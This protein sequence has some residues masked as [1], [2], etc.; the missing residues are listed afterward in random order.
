MTNV[1]ILHVLC[2]LVPWLC[3]ISDHAVGVVDQLRVLRVRPRGM[4]QQRMNRLQ[5]ARAVSMQPV[6]RHESS[7]NE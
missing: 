7:H 1:Y 5:D 4:G 2:E 3:R 6:P